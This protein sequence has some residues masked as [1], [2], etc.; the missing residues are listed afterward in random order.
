MDG[1]L[2]I[3]YV[4]VRDLKSALKFYRDQLGL[5]ES[6][7]EGESTVAFKLSGTEIELMVDL[8]EEGMP[9]TAGPMF[10]VPSVAEFYAANRGA[11][12]F[13]R[14]PSA[15]PPGLWATAKDPSGNCIYL[16]DLSKTPQG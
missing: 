1:K 10:L 12:E 13:A 7:R 11:M 4:P 14:K 5:E 16:F 8:I 2:S 6:W 9:D 15:I 3:I